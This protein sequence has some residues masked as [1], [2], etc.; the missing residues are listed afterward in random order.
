MRDSATVI[1]CEFTIFPLKKSRKENIL[2]ERIFKSN[3]SSENKI[4]LLQ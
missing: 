1:E 3:P 2:F 4:F